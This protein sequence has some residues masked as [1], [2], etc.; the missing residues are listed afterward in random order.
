[1]LIIDQWLSV[2]YLCPLQAKEWLD[3]IL[4]H[5]SPDGWLGPAPHRGDDM[6]YW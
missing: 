6:L 4:A 3:Y 1:M 2:T 5:A